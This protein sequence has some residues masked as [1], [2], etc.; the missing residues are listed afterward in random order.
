MEIIF[1]VI[2][3]RWIPLTKANDAELL[4]FLWYVPEKKMVEQTVELSGKRNAK[5]FIVTSV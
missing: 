1:C 3:Y 2:G 5:A 4:C